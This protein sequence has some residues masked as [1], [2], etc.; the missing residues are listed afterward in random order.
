MILIPILILLIGLNI[1]L[2]SS[3]VYSYYLND[4]QSLDYTTLVLSPNELSDQIS[5]FSWGFFNDEI[6]ITENAG[7]KEDPVFDDT[8]AEVLFEIRDIL[9]K[10][11]ALMLVAIAF[12]IALYIYFIKKEYKKELFTIC[13]ISSVASGILIIVSKFLVGSTKVMS[14]LYEKYIGITLAKDSLLR[15]LFVEHGSFN[16]VVSV[17]MLS[18]SLIALAVL[19]YVTWRLTKTPRIYKRR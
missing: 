8:E 7:Y 4:S 17:A 2:R 10:S 3:E 16:G 13:K 15:T 12:G 11:F 18:I 1:S 9:N 6:N 19:F 14:G 5:D